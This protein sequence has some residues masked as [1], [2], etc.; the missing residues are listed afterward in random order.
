[1][2]EGQVAVLSSGVLS[3]A[4]SLEVLDALR[5]SRLYREDQ[6]SYMLY[7]NKELPGFLDKNRLPADALGRSPLL[8]RMV[9]DGDRR[10]VSRDVRGAVHFNGTF[11][12]AGDLSAAMDRAGI[13]GRER[14]VVLDLFEETFNHRE[15]TGRSGTFYAYEGLG[16]IYWHMVSKLLVATQECYFAALDDG[17]PEAD[18]LAARYRAILEGTG[19]HKTPL[20]YGAF[21][22]D[23][24]SHTPWGKGARQPGMTG[25][26]KE[27]IICRFGELGVRVSGGKVSFHPT[28]LD[29]GE[30][31]PDGTLALN[32]ASGGRRGKRYQFDVSVSGT[33]TLT[34]LL[35]GEPYR[36]YTAASGAV[37][38]AVVSDAASF[39]LEF[40]YTPGTND[41]G[42][43]TLS[44]FQ[45]FAGTMLIFR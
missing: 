19:I 28:L 29:P 17:A 43:A 15:F 4:E 32:W 12:N 41:E 10:L 39:S 14:E 23:A 25:Q 13:A 9:A 36:S 16:S 22:T 45:D 8:A 38:D 2:L 34:V 40:A 5:A 44:H 7:P 6:R 27:D 33:G 1:M 20:Q 31:L 30:F 35:N 11:R 37:S 26:V 42:G 3:H 24:Y 18:S 21:P